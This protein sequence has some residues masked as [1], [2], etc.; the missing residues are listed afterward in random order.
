MEEM[1]NFHIAP[2]KI[3]KVLYPVCRKVS[4]LTKDKL[5]TFAIRERLSV[6]GYVKKVSLFLHLSF[7]YLQYS[8][9]WL[10]VLI[11]LQY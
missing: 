9:V 2:E 3:E 1:E 6:L 4:D 7:H 11:I 10:K 5:M 8:C